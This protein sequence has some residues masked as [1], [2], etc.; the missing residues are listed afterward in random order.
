M[1][2]EAHLHKLVVAEIQDVTEQIQRA[3]ERGGLPTE[4]EAEAVFIEGQKAFDRAERL[5]WRVA[6]IAEATCG[7]DVPDITME[8]IGVVAVVADRLADRAQDFAELA[9][10]LRKPISAL[11]VIRSEQLAAKAGPDELLDGQA[12]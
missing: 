3:I 2:S 7:S 9:E 10:K 5:A 12:E 4:A 11:D 1:T 8:Q 6:G